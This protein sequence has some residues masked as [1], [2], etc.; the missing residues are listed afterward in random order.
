MEAD[1]I[2]MEGVRGIGLSRLDYDPVVYNGH[3]FIGISSKIKRTNGDQD[4]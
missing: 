3:V 4:V 1:N 2:T